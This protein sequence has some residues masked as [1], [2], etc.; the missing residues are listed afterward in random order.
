MLECAKVFFK[1]RM[2]IEKR[3]TNL[4]HIMTFLPLKKG[5]ITDLSLRIL[6]KNGKSLL[7]S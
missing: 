5:K 2:A 3:E 6:M 7:S 1:G 4:N